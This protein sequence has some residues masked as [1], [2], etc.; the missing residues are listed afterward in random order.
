MSI[1]LARYGVWQHSRDVDAALAESVER[2]GFGVLWIGSASGDLALAEDALAATEHLTVATGIINVWRNPADQ[3]AESFTR[4]DERFPGRFVLGVGTGHPEVTAEY[5][6]PYGALVDYLDTLDGLGVPSD[7]IVL[8]ALGQKMLRLAAQRTAGA[9]PYLITPAHTRRARETLGAGVLL[10]PEQKVILGGPDDQT[11]ATARTKVNNPYLHLNNYVR[12][13]RDLG[14]A[15]ADLADGGSDALID[16]LVIQGNPAAV[17][18]G[19]NAH[20]EAGADHVAVQVLGP[21]IIGALT[22]LAPALGLTAG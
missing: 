11:R 17:A 8:A 18:V 14:W 10:A 22:A 2:L 7:R 16:A 20:L 1:Q 3:V 5:R 19:V 9:H 13:L 4:V 15:D 21:D 6:S 12:N